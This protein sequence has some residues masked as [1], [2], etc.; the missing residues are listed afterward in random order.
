MKTLSNIFILAGILFLQS[1]EPATSTIS[2]GQPLAE[3]EMF[4]FQTDSTYLVNDTGIDNRASSIAECQDTCDANAVAWDIDCTNVVSL[5]S[6]GAADEAQDLPA[7]SLLPT[8]KSI[9][10][11]DGVV[12]ATSFLDLLDDR[13]VAM[14]GNGFAVDRNW[15]GFDD[16]GAT[17]FN[18][19]NWVNNAAIG[20]NFAD[21]NTTGD[22]HGTIGCG[23]AAKPFLC[24]SWK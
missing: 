14:T 9:Y 15:T 8:N 5:L 20:G 10:T 16:G 6:Y 21:V 18:C 13:D 24:L 1:C 4:I 11:P 12:V 22:W 2:L 19:D 23:S 7:T 3:P 17:T